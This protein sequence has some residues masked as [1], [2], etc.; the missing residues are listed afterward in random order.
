MAI[1]RV[2]ASVSSIL[3]H[4]M[5]FGLEGKLLPDGLKATVQEY[6]DGYELYDHVLQA[7]RNPKRMEEL[8]LTDYALRRFALAGTPRDWVTRVEQLAQAGVARIWMTL[9]GGELDRQARDLRLIG[10][11]VLPNFV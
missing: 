6:V 8:G 9:G 4:S 7:G 10:E 11:G 1:D 2:K 3:N 5:R